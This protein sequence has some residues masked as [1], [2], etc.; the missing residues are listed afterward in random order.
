[1]LPSPVCGVSPV[2][3]RFP[4]EE[5]PEPPTGL[6]ATYPVSP[7]D[8][9]RRRRFYLREGPNGCILRVEVGTPDSFTLSMIPSPSR[10][11]FSCD[12]V[13]VAFSAQR[14]VVL[15]PL[16]FSLYCTRGTCASSLVRSHT[17]RS[18][19]ARHLRACPVREVV[20]VTWGPR[21]R[22][23]VEGVL[24][25][26][27]VLELAAVKADSGAEGKMVVK[28]VACESLAELSWLVWDAEDSLEFYP[29]QPS[30]S[31][32]SL[33]RSLRPPNHLER[34]GVSLPSSGK[35]RVGRRRQGGSLGPRS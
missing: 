32:F 11:W 10:P 17:S 25:A 26:T 8:C 34:S 12:R 13:Y 21:P 9:A 28:T 4:K 15:P 30:Q 5:S 35:A 20:T 18:P 22:E 29:A 24:R 1:M 2:S 14:Q 6:K 23:P 7:S 27:S 16:P 3:G 33:P 19:G 31:F